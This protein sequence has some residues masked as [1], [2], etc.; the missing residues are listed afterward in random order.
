MFA[1]T[2]EERVAVVWVLITAFLGV[3]ANYCVKA[4]SYSSGI[5][6]INENIGK[7]NI[8]S[9]GRQDLLSV[10]GIGEKLAG[11][12][13]DYRQEK[14]PFSRVEDLMSVKGMTSFR[15]NKIKEYICLE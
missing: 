12:I 1:I 9:A 8:N 2:R 13:I 3:V 15:Y 14:G 5:S 10:R 6:S 4:C 11:R 7:I